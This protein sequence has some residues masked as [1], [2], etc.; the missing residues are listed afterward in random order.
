M[1]L[2]S[3]SALNSRFHRCCDYRRHC[4]HFYPKR[5]RALT[6]STAPRAMFLSFFLSLSVIIFIPLILPLCLLY[7]S[8]FY[9]SDLSSI[10]TL[11][12]LCWSLWSFLFA[13]CTVVIF[14]SLILPLCL[15]Y[16]C[17]FHSSDSSSML[18]V[19]L[20]L[21]SLW[22][23]LYTFATIASLTGLFIIALHRLQGILNM[24]ALTCQTLKSQAVARRYCCF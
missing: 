20:L 13:Y 8:Y 22:S 5:K 21:L 4:T 16:S 17:Y 12:L 24:Q 3:P 23:F 9:P 7:S 6:T 15:L 14:I 11:Q 18:T 1:V 2:W 10:L 19:Q